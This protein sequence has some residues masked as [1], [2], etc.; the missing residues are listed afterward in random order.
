MLKTVFKDMTKEDRIYMF[1]GIFA[2]IVLVIGGHLHKERKAVEEAQW[3]HYVLTHEFFCQGRN[4]SDLV[5]DEEDGRLFYRDLDDK[6]KVCDYADV[7]IN[8]L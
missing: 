2:I 1:F 7:T 6:I 8:D 5:I 4:I 3:T